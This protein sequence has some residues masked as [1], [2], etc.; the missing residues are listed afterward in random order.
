MVKS[1]LASSLILAS[2]ASAALQPISIKGTKFF[3][4]NGTQFFMKGVAYQEDVAG[5]GGETTADTFLDPLADEEK[6]KRD[7]PLLAEAG[8]NTIRTYAIRPD[9]DHSACMKMLDDAGIYVISDLSEPNTSIN[10]DDPQWNV[11]LFNR[12]KAVVDELQQFSN[13]VGFFAGN[14]VSNN[15]SNTGA[16]AFVKA[17]VRDTKK[18]IKDKGYREMGVGYAAND[19]EEIRVDI[20]QYFNCGGEEDSIDYWGYNIYSWCGTDSSFT[21]SGYDK[22]VEFFSSYSVPVFFAEYGCNVPGGAE[23]RVFEDAEALYSDQMTGVFSG[24]IVYMYFQETNDYGLVEIDDDGNAS[25]M[26]NFDALKEKILAA[27]PQ[28]VDKDSY[29]SQNTQGECPDISDTWAAS[30]VLPPTPNEQLCNCMFESLSCTVADNTNE[31]DYG[32]IFGYVCAADAGVCAGIKADTKNG[33]YGSYSMCSAKHQLGYALN[34]YYLSRSSA[35]SACDFDGKAKT[36]TPTS[37]SSCSEL[38]ASAAES[39]SIV[40]TATGGVSAG[41]SGESASSDNENA[42]VRFGYSVIGGAYIITAMLVGA[43]VVVM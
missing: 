35:S 20:S 9:A 21:I 13:V 30:A 5:A 40:A 23:G 11:E 10:R 29:E 28:G 15:A 4:E 43:A 31:E 17:A 6:C 33:L 36:M 1:A 3:Y 16:S 41:G 37:D 25:T 12:Y 27:R 32:E 8:T 2:T 38:L 39:N 19:D 18:Y 26:K 7:V 22:Q 34:E 24:G 42:A 14:E